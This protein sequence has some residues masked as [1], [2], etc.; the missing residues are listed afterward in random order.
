[1]KSFFSRNEIRIA[2]IAFITVFLGLIRSLA[3]PFRLQYYAITPLDFDHV[4]PFLLGGLVAAGGL[5]L[6]TIFS[7]Y[8]RFRLIVILAVLTILSMLLVKFTYGI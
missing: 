5:M 4:K 6:M 2:R 8:N 1:M 3:E 7:F